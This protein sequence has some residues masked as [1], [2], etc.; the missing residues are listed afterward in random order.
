MGPVATLI[1][2][3]MFEELAEYARY[4]LLKGKLNLSY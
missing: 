4:Y 3:P 2:H 1:N